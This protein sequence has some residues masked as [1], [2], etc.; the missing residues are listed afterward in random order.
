MQFS[1]YN[2]ISESCQLLKTREVNVSVDNLPGIHPA[3]DNWVVHGVRHCKPISTEENF[4]N[5]GPLVDLLE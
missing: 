3:V 5:V 2:F 4:L 1:S